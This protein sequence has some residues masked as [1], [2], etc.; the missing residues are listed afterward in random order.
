MTTNR[1]DKILKSPV[2]ELQQSY[3][4]LQQLR[5]LVEKAE[6]RR[7]N[8]YGPNPSGRGQPMKTADDLEL[9]PK[10]EV[11]ALE[12]NTKLKADLEE[13]SAGELATALVE[14][15][16]ADLPNI[17]DEMTGPLGDLR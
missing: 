5:K 12:K 1:R 6:K 15:I 4:Q 9:A 11:V 14:I 16:G 13:K 7:T 17:S 2:R 3:V 10:F 8:L